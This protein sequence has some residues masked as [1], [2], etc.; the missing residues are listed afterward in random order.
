MKLMKIHVV[1]VMLPVSL[2]DVRKKK[3]Y[4]CFC[5]SPEHRDSTNSEMFLLCT[6]HKMN[7]VQH[8][9]STVSFLVFCRA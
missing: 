1:G 9:C 5:K 6:H 2:A 3:Y 7:S 4:M 8:Y